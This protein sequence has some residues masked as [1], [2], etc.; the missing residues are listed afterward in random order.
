MNPQS[1]PVEYIRGS[2]SSGLVS[3]LTGLSAAT[4]Q[5]WHT[6]DL[7]VASQRRG[8]RGVKRLYSW[9]DYQRLCIMASL[10]LASVPTLRIR[11]AVEFLD[12]MYPEWWRMSVCPYSGVV[13]GRWG[14]HVMLRQRFDVIVDSPGGQMSFRDAMAADADAIADSLSGAIDELAIKGPLFMKHAYRDAVS[15]RPELNSG[16][17][18]LVGTSLETAFVAAYV[19]RSS[20]EEVASIFRLSEFALRRA[21]EFEEAA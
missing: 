8:E 12:A 17:P 2:L 3:K 9:V 15:M 18:T 4:L 20:I 6:S 10:K 16:Q 21:I 11:T 7:Q 1:V 5:Y 19:K 14:V 13:G